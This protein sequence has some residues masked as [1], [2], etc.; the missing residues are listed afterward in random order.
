VSSSTSP[1]IQGWHLRRSN[2]ARRPSGRRKLLTTLEETPF[3]VVGLDPAPGLSTPQV[4]ER[5][6]VLTIVAYSLRRRKFS[7]LFL[8]TVQRPVGLAP[9]RRNAKSLSERLAYPSF[10]ALADELAD[11]LTGRVVVAHRPDV[12]HD[13]LSRGFRQARRARPAGSYVSTVGLVELLYPKRNRGSLLFDTPRDLARYVGVP[14]DA[15]TTASYETRVTARIFFHCLNKL[16]RNQITEWSAFI[17][18]EARNRPGG[19]YV[20]GVPLVLL[21]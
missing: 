5:Y 19:Y 21:R 7:R 17:E 11:L 8:R 4:W 15:R 14:C 18:Y 12:L 10:E 1:P 9:G 20:V 13:F 2:P 3:C 16:R 6:D